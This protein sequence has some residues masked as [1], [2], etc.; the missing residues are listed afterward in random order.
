M[1][2][3]GEQLAT[4]VALIIFNRPDKTQ[5]VFE[6]IRS[7]KP[8]KLYVISDGPRDG[9]HQDVELV[10]RSRTVTEEIDWDCEVVR[11]YSETNLGCKHRI[12]SGLNKLFDQ[13]P[14]AIIL[15]DDCLPHHDFFPYA[16]E[17]LARFENNSKIFSIGG[18]IWE[19]PDRLD[20][21]SYFFSK[22]LSVWGW[23]TWADRWRL[24]DPNMTDWPQL[25]S[26][27]LLKELAETPLE[28]VYWQKVLDMTYEVNPALSQAWDY[29]VQLA[30]WRAGMLAI[31]P[32]VNLIQN[33]GLDSDATHTRVNSPAISSRGT[34][35]LTWPLKH[36]DNQERNLELDARVNQVRI[37]G[38]L[39]KLLIDRT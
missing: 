1:A 10:R 2:P 20:T 14:K 15:E 21:D 12:I 26:S 13:V 5:R 35:A 19:F 32:H 28:F 18:H 11:L 8:K 31:R 16:E 30:M 33:I 9:H 37:G 27:T 34:T 4:P 22:Y 3:I 17:L 36:P 24:V 25:R 38:A 6:Q 29:T 7:Q 23:A 39:K